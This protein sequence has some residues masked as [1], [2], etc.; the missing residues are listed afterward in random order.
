MRQYVVGG[1]VA[2]GLAAV[3]V[4]C[5]LLFTDLRVTD[6]SAKDEAASLFLEGTDQTQ[7]PDVMG[8]PETAARHSLHDAGLD[9]HV[10]YVGQFP[11]STPSAPV[12]HGQK[13]PPLSTVKIGSAVTLYERAR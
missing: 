13:P 12:V 11:Y 9:A 5:L 7:V 2:L 4:V 3:V 10:V 8:T 6:R 1:V